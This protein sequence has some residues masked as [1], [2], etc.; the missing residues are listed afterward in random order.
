MAKSGGI[1]LAT[2]SGRCGCARG[3]TRW[4]SVRPAVEGVFLHG[5]QIVG[6]EIRADL[7]ALVGDGPQLTGLRFPLQAGGIADA[8]SVDAARA[9]RR[10]DFEHV[11][12]TVLD[13]QTVLADIAVG[14]DAHIQFL[15]IGTRQ[16]RLGPVMVDGVG[17]SASSTPRSPMLVSPDLYG[18]LFVGG[19]PA[20]ADT[21]PSRLR[22]QPSARGYH[23]AA[24]LS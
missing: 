19:S 13:F 1:A 20:R 21:G 15:T 5:R 8:R 14:P 12:A 4:P 2:R 9:G 22:Q 10:V 16:K 24:R 6:H 18:I 17:R 11:S 3:S 23:I 7:I